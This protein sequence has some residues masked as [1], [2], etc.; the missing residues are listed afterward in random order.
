MAALLAA[1]Q[2]KVYRRG[3]VICRKCASP[4]YVYEFSTLPDEFSVRCPH[5]GDRDFYLKRAV[6]IQDLPERRKKPR[7]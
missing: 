6:T 3:Q 2:K 1:R 4:I 5:C 7:H